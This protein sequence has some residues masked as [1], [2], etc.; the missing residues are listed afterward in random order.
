MK[1]A[2]ITTE[3]SMGILCVSYRTVECDVMFAQS[4]FFLSLF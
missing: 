1:I 3:E 4:T 2:E